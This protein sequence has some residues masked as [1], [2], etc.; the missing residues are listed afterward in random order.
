[1][2]EPTREQI[3]E[4]LDEVDALD[5]PDGAYWQLVHEKLGLDYGD[6]FPLMLNDPEFFDVIMLND[7]QVRGDK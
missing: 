3:K 1:M 6:V 4:V 5:L 7:E 2:A